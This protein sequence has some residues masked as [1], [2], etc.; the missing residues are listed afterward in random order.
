MPCVWKLTLASDAGTVVVLILDVVLTL[1]VIN[2]DFSPSSETCD[3]S[4]ILWYEDCFPS[5]DTADF[6]DT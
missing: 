6:S 1:S 5:S 2:L 3:F 4:V